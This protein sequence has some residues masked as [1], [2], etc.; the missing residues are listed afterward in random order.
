M[1]LD[2][3]FIESVI[4]DAQ[5][6]GP[7]IVFEGDWIPDSR[8]VTPKSIFVALCG[9]NVDGHS[10]VA[11]AFA[12]GAIAALIAQDQL[13]KVAAQVSA[14]ATLIVVPDAREALVQLATAW[15][16]QFTIPVV[17]ITGSVGKTTTKEL[18]ASILN[19]HGMNCLASS[20]NFN[21]DIGLAVTLLRMRAEHQIVVVEMGISRRGEMARL[22]HMARPTTAVFTMLGHSHMEGLGSL[23]DIAAEKRAIFSFLQPDGIGIINGDQPLLSGVAYAHPVIKF[24][25]KMVN[26]VQARQIQVQQ[27]GL[28]FILKLYRERRRIQ[29]T[30]ENEARVYNVLAAAAV[31]HFFGV[32]FDTI[33]RGIEQGVEVPGRFEKHMIN[34][35]GSWI[36]DDSYNASP[37]SMKDALKAFEQ[38]EGHGKKIAVLG[39]M[40]ELGVDSAFWHRQ[41][42][43]FLR[44]APSLSHVIFVGEQM[45]WAEKTVPYGLSYEWHDNWQAASASLRQRIKKQDTEACILV[46]A[47]RG[48][49]LNNLVR[50][51]IPQS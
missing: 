26:H 31:T 21:T 17:G 4:P 44:K 15:R 29:L 43:R 20:G 7:E 18:I 27:K 51:I 9:S 22:A 50:D 2:R 12:R 23:A 46:K 16:A 47:S 41:L 10:F 36:I 25:C 19:L 45:K 48:M 37:E 6:R 8:A 42:G 34:T 38:I 14:Q 49:A 1:K 3:K 35:S 24:G 28:T 39:D 5:I 11:D 13:A 32:P 30:T 40:L 33:V